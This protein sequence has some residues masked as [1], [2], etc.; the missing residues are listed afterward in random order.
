MTALSSL[1]TATQNEED[2]HDTDVSPPPPPSTACGTPQ[3]TPLKTTALSS[4][5]TAT[6]NEEDEHDT[7]VSP[8]PPPST[9]CG[10]PQDTPLKTTTSPCVSAAT[11]NED[12]AQ[13]TECAVARLSTSFGAAQLPAANAVDDPTSTARTAMT[14][15]R[16]RRADV[17]ESTTQRAVCRAIPASA[18]VGVTGPPCWKRRPVPPQS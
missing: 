8:P 2:E 18:C 7:D 13:D 4:L 9:A 10:T 17:Q 1:S 14:A 3:D 5:S 16:P 6:Q 11:Q 15:A 12:E